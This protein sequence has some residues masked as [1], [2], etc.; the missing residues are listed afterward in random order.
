MDETEKKQILLDE[1]LEAVKQC[2]IKFGG[3]SEL[4]TEDEDV[5]A[6]LC[7]KL[8]AILNHGLKT[9]D[10]LVL[11]KERVANNIQ[12]LINNTPANNYPQ[13]KSPWSFIKIHLNRHELERYM[14]LK[15]VK[16]DAGRA[17]AWLRSSLNEHSLERYFHMMTNDSEK[18]SQFY[19]PYAFMLDPERNTMLANMAR[20][21]GS[22]LFAIKIDNEA[23]NF[24]STIKHS[25]GIEEDDILAA[26]PVTTN[27][28]QK[29]KR[30]KKKGSSQVISF[31]ED[32]IKAK[33]TS[34][35]N[36][37]INKPIDKV[38]FEQKMSSLKDAE[39]APSPL[40][41]N[42]VH[43]NSKGQD[44]S[45]F[46]SKSPTDAMSVLSIDTSSGAEEITK[47]TPMK[48]SEIGAL[49][50]LSPNGHDDV[51]S[52][53]SMSIKSFEDQDY[54][55]AMSS[56]IATPQPPPITVLVLPFFVPWFCLVSH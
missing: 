23:L 49:I 27:P 24:W 54:A 32:E 2:Q 37:V 5:I 40:T 48:N 33:L 43:L 39:R 19:D 7:K 56:I 9:Q 18:L 6:E 26:K 51:M 4:A 41:Y 22:I 3:K 29:P 15:Q 16:T 31:D 17:R 11:I 10:P 28:E 14:L 47:L 42:D 21:L 13:N 45:D 46:L 55:S 34:S 36:S 44:V 35:K 25:E 1:L 30:I 20:G 53:D 12:S 52:E 38:D 8:E 50:P